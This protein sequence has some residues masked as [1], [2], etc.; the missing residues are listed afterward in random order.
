MTKPVL[1]RRIETE[2]GTFIVIGPDTWISDDGVTFE[3]DESGLARRCSRAFDPTLFV[4]LFSGPQW[5]Q[6][7]LAVGAEEKN[8]V[9]T[10][11]YRIDEIDGGRW[12]HRIA[13]RRHDRHVDRRQRA[14]RVLGIDRVSARRTISIQVTNIDDPA[15]TVEAPN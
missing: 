1:S 15:N 7:A 5:A 14:P 8:G 4:A 13:G 6:S 12:V 3:K 2:D 9:S 10:T 11:H